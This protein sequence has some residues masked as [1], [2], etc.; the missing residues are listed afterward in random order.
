[1]KLFFSTEHNTS[2]CKAIDTLRNRNLNLLALVFLKFYFILIDFRKGEGERDG[3][4]NHERE[5]LRL[6]PAWPLPGIPSLKP[7]HVP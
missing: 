1:M 7:R 2:I 3:G 5:S 4:I 6:P